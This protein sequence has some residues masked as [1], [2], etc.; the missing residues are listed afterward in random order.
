MNR[1]LISSLYDVLDPIISSSVKSG[2]KRIIILRQKKLDKK[3]EKAIDRLKKTFKKRTL[4]KMKLANAD[5]SIIV[6]DDILKFH[7][8]D[9]RHT[10]YHKWIND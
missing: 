6:N 5:A 9:R 10:Y 8:H 2:T 1:V 7:N 3:M 4:N